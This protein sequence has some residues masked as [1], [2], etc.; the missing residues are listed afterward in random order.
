M[1]YYAANTGQ[2]LTPP[3]GAIAGRQALPRSLKW[4]LPII[5]EIKTLPSS[6]PAALDNRL[7]SV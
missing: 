2:I 3:N 1:E 6:L 5:A 4:L 7:A